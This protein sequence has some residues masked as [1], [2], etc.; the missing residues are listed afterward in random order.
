MSEHVNEMNTLSRSRNLHQA[1][2]CRVLIVDMQEKLLPVV[3]G[4]S[5]VAS[6]CRAIADAANIFD[7]PIRITE[8]YPK[9]L[10][11]TF[12]QL[13]SFDPEPSEK[14]AFSAA[15]AS[16]FGRCQTDDARDRV[17]VCGIETHICVLQTAF[18]LH[19]RGWRVSVVADAVGARHT[20]DHTIGLQRMRDGGIEVVTTEMVLFEWAERA[21]TPS[22]KKISQIVRSRD[23]PSISPS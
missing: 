13:K 15:D 3:D 5:C 12:T 14:L 20:V 11:S 18:E 19:N 23:E 2:N 9:G 17:V 8:Q 16:G 6:G 4:A 10:G 22:F 1:E 7:I 21:G